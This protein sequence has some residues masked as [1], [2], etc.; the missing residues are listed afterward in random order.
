MQELMG[1]FVTMERSFVLQSVVKAID[2]DSVDTTDPDSQ[3]SMVIDDVFFLCRN[4]VFRATTSGDVPTVCAVVNHVAA[5]VATELKAHLQESLTES[6]RAFEPFARNLKNLHQEGDSHPLV[7]LWQHRGDEQSVPSSCS[8]PH[9]LN[10]LIVASQYA[11][12]LI[13]ECKQ[14]FLEYFPDDPKLAMFEHCLKEGFGQAQAEFEKMHETA[15]RQGLTYL[16]VHLR[17]MMKPLDDMSFVIS[18]PEFNDYQVNDPFVK[19]FLLQCEVIHSFLET[20]MVPESVSCILLL[21]VEQVCKRVETAVLQKDFSMLGGVQLDHDVR[22]LLA[23]FSAH[24][25]PRSCFLRLTDLGELLSLEQRQD[26]K[27]LEHV[28]KRWN[29]SKE[30]IA[31]VLA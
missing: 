8:Y 27:E 13:D 10:N 24:G 11:T 3:T 26:L 12:K 15:C 23:W 17:P 19:G 29:L 4:S 31:T 7:K 25:C 2:E 16:K 9:C 21:L 5:C 18:S 6:L 20:T 28:G 14:Q 1:S 30:E 22:Q